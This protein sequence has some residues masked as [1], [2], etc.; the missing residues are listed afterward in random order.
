[1]S[2]PKSP[3]I[4]IPIGA[5]IY[6]T[7]TETVS[8]GVRTVSIHG[9]GGPFTSIF[10]KRGAFETVLPFASIVGLGAG[11]TFI[12]W[13]GENYVMKHSLKEIQADDNLTLIG[14][15]EG[16]KVQTSLPPK[17]EPNFASPIRSARMPSTVHS[18]VAVE[19][20]EVFMAKKGLSQTEFATRAKTTDKTVRKIRK[21]ADIKRSML[22]DIAK[23]L[24]ITREELLKES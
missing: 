11:R 3:K 23:A 22:D 17:S 8:Q 13:D 18:Q 24:G 21:T 7:V 6:G 4:R 15:L 2:E 16:S 5:A 1:L 14:S 9:D 19:R 20:I 12:A 10:V